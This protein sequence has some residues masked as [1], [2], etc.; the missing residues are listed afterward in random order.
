MDGLQ[1]D[2]EHPGGLAFVAPHRLVDGEDV[3]AF[4]LGEGLEI[5]GGG[6]QSRGLGPALG[7]G[8]LEVAGLDL[9][10]GGIGMI[11]GGCGALGA[12]IWF[13][14]M[15]RP[16]EKIA[17]SAEGTWAGELLE[18][19]HFV[20]DHEMECSEIVGRAFADPGDHGRYVGAGGCA[21]IIDVLAAADG[22]MRAGSKAATHQAA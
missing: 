6:R 21:A 18:R 3:A 12:A 17:F 4:H 7:L 16:E 19:F 9:S 22:A 10:A 20:A 2:P 14:G 13:T 15:R 8:Q 5:A 11:G 1:S